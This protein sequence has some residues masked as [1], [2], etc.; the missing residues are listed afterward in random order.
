NDQPICPFKYFILGDEPSIYDLPIAP[1][2]RVFTAPIQDPTVIK[3]GQGIF[4]LKRDVYNG[5]TTNQSLLSILCKYPLH[6]RHANI[7]DATTCHP[8]FSVGGELITLAKSAFILCEMIEWNYPALSPNTPTYAE[9]NTPSTSGNKHRKQNEFKRIAENS[10]PIILQP[11]I[12]I[13]HLPIEY[14]LPIIL[15]LHQQSS[16]SGLSSHID[17]GKQPATLEKY[18]RTASITTNNNFIPNHN[19]T[20]TPHEYSDQSDASE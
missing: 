11:K 2:F 16:H 20:A 1:A 12:S 14:L 5:V 18:M 7:K 8:I 15:P 19:T 4:R 17:K 13:K 3:N 6:N 10:I 9:T